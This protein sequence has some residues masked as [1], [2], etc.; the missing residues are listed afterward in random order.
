MSD[1]RDP[2][3]Y[4]DDAPLLDAWLGFT[5]RVAAGQLNPF[6][7]PGHKHRQDLVGDVTK[8]DVPLF[9]GL[10]NMKQTGG[11]L[12]AAELRAAEAWGADW[13]RMSVGGSTHANQ[14]AVLALGRPGQSV[15]VSRTLHR[16]VLLGIA[17][18]GLRPVWGWVAGGVRGVLPAACGA[19]AGRGPRSG[20]CGGGGGAPGAGGRPVARGGGG[21]GGGGRRGRRIGLRAESSS[22]GRAPVCTPVPS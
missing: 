10:D 19:G 6:S 20:G 17:L 21:W 8:G 3:G 5:A 22:I 13:C 16:S 4:A 2:R 12:E 1:P 11:L 14:A 18:A 9:A 15:V 7:I